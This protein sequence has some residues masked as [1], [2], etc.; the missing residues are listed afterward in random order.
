MDILEQIKDLDTE[1]QVVGC[2]ESVIPFIHK[3]FEHDTTHYKCPAK[4][5]GKNKTISTIILD[6]HYIN[7]RVY[8]PDYFE[9][10]IEE[11]LKTDTIYMVLNVA[12]CNVYEKHGHNNALIINKNLKSVER[13]EPRGHNKNKYYDDLRIENAIKS[14]VEIYFVGFRYL[15]PYVFI[16]DQGPQ[17]HTKLDLGLDFGRGLCVNY[18]ILYIYLRCKEKLEPEETIKFMN[19][20]FLDINI[21]KFTKFV[22]SHL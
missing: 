22:N 10:W 17:S 20:H 15:S 14:F 6:C 2:G 11:Y 12:L 9:T 5:M 1:I 16:G 4:I 8:V 3:I 18:T 7:P 21:L 19:N 13:F